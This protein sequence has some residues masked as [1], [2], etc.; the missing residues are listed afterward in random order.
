MSKRTQITNALVE[1]VNNNLN[2][3]D[4]NSNIYNNAY[5][6]LVFWDEVN[7][8][9]YISI[10]AG[11]ENRQYLPANFKWGFLEVVIRIYVQ[12]EYP[13][14][15]LED[16]IEDIEAL[17]DANNN[18]VYDSESGDTT[19]LISILSINT[20]QGFFAPIGA[21]EIVIQVQYDL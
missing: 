16:F 8:F 21:G 15:K 7:D 18:L 19:E 12:D 14:E 4:Y 20:D 11:G 17:L 6:K 1:L 10:V 13:Q 2:S 9:P 5:N 3:I